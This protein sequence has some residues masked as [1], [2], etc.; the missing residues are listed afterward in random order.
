MDAED[1]IARLRDAQCAL[2]SSQSLRKYLE[3][4]TIDARDA[5]GNALRFGDVIEKWQARSTVPIMRAIEGIAG[6]NPTYAGPL[7]FWRDLPQG[8]DKTSGIARICNGAL[9]FCRRP[10]RIGVFAKDSIQA[11]RIWQFMRDEAQ[12]K[13]LNPWLGQRLKFI[14]SPTRK[15]FGIPTEQD[16]IISGGGELEIHDSDAA[17]NA[18]HKFDITICEELTWWPEKG[19]ELLDQLYT[20]R[21]KIKGAVF[22]VLGNAGILKTWQH[23]LYLEA[24][25]D[26]D[27]DVYRTEGSVA[28]WIPPEKLAQDKR[29]VAPSIARRVYDNEWISEDEQTYL[30]RAELDAVEAR[31]RELGLK[32]YSNA[33]PGVKYVA[34]I[35]YGSVKD[36]CAMCVLGVYPDGTN[37]VVKLDVVRGS[38]ATPVS[39][40]SV[41]TWAEMVNIAFR[42]AW[43]VDTYQMEWF[44]QEHALWPIERFA[45][46]GG[47]ANYKMAEHV[48]TLV[49]NRE[50]LWPPEIGSVRMTDRAGREIDYTLADEFADLV[51]VD[52]PSGYR[53]D[54]KANKHDDRATAVGMAAYYASQVDLSRPFAEKTP[55]PSLDMG[56]KQHIADLAAP[57]EKYNVWGTGGS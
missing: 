29:T 21:H 49:V 43:V 54:H 3:V 10:I 51:T 12:T 17:G 31:S 14:S 42:P 32:P 13:R 53:W 2:A 55:I 44:V 39:L 5:D 36:W 37:R 40:A 50:L 16:G 52:L 15:V 7:Y 47:L 27:W 46:R 26:P 11:G 4:V 33:R 57:V 20:R 28:G 34:S 23:D 19:K 8:H 1:E 45:Y 30:T 22:V 6:I 18:G 35:D 48:R 9:A 56:R 25:Q 24:Q 41:N 38:R